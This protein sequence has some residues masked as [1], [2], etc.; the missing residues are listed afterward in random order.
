M[1][2]L[3]LL[4]VGWAALGSGLLF[5]EEGP[6]SPAKTNSLEMKLLPLDGGKVFLAVHETTVGQYRT[7]A[8]AA[9]R[10]WPKADFSQSDSHPAVHIS[11]E[12]AMAFCA[13][14]TLKEVKSGD[15]PAGSRYRLPTDAEWSFAVGLKAVDDLEIPGIDFQYPWGEGWPPPAEAGNYARELGV[16]RFTHTSPVGSFPANELGFHD[17]GGNVWEWCLDAFNNSPDYRIL[18]GASWRMRLPGDLLSRTRIGNRPDLRL[19]VYGFR[20]AWEQAPST[21]GAKTTVD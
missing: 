3:F 18:R 17:L 11:W 16:D 10:P 15:I 8:R 7:F 9:K 6:D 2:F 13:W 19:P 14:L 12:D 21:G 4:V 5:S 1:R 20:V